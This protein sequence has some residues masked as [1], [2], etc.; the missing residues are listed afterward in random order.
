PE[1]KSGRA[2]LEKWPDC[3]GSLG[4]AISEAIEYM[5]DHPD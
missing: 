4:L 3:P 1:T 5:I 2:M